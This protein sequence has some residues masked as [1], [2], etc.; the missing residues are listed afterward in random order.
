LAGSITLS[1]KIISTIKYQEMNNMG[2]KQ[3]QITRT[4]LIGLLAAI[5]VGT[6]EFLLHFDS[7]GRFGEAKTYEFM[8]GISANRTTVGHFLAILGA[9]LYIPGFWH[10]MKMLEPANRVASRIAFVIMSYG[11]IIGVAWI[12]SRANISSIVNYEQITDPSYLVSLYAFRY[13]NLLQITRLAVLFFSLIFLWLTL[14]GRSYYPRWVAVFNPI[15]LIL[16]SFTVWFFT[17]AIG[18]FLMPVALNIAFGLLFLISIYYSRN[19]NAKER[20]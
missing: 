17:P 16:F 13:E 2:T 15:L 14:S 10:L 1:G 11:M 20:S 7:L 5:L 12:G 9:P 8:N 18:I 4:G 3:V 19:I 6:G